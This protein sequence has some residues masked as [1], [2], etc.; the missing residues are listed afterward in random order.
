MDF[1]YT[2]EQKMIK[3]AARGFLEKACPN[4]EW[5]LEMERDEKGFTPELWKGMAE[6]GWMGIMFPE[7]YGGIGGSFLDL[8]VLL[9]EMGYAALPGPFFSTVILGGIAILEAGTDKQKDDLLP[10]IAEG[11]CLLT[12]ALI[13]PATTCYDP[14]YIETSAKSAGDNYIING[15]KLFVPNANVSDVIIVAARTSGAAGDKSGITL[16]LVDSKTPG[17]KTTL[18][19]TTAGDKL[20]EVVF[21]AV[22]VPQENILGHL[23]GAGTI[24]EK[25]LQYAAVG[26]C[27]E[28]LGGAHKVMEITVAYAKERVQFGKPIGA[29]QAVQHLCANQKMAIEGSIYITYK[30]AWLLVNGSSETRIISSAK[31][32]VSDAGKKVAA[33]GH[34]IFGGT[35]YIVEHP[36]PIYSRRAKAAEYAFGNANYHRELIASNLGL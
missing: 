30:A 27:A 21:N 7:K 11:K 17:I 9:E 1:T 23:N 33:I 29:Y 26:K 28:M 5:Y 14:S 16:F 18:L 6:L 8:V 25:V 32:W 20:C 15:T 19:K 34:Q 2:E 22:K 12:M 13:E 4:V 35:G 3:E 36:M 24:I 31:A 10:R